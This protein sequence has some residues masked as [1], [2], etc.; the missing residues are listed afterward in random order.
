MKV[1]DFTLTVYMLLYLFTPNSFEETIR[2]RMNGFQLDAPDVY[3]LLASLVGPAILLSLIGLIAL[4]LQ[5]PLSDVA[6]QWVRMRWLVAMCIVVGVGGLLSI[7]LFSSQ[8]RE[9]TCHWLP[10]WSL[11]YVVLVLA[12]LNGLSPYLGYKTQGS[13]TMFSNL[14]TEHG[15]WNHLLMPRSMRVIDQ[16][17]DRLV[18]I[19]A[20]DDVVLN[21]LYVEQDLL[22]T[23]FEVRRRAMKNPSLSIT[24][25]RGNQEV[26]IG[27]ISQDPVLGAP[28]SVLARKLLVFRPVTPDGRPFV[29][30]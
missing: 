21:D 28:L 2:E 19:V 27:S 15:H 18:R 4:S 24:V 8:R 7:G 29:T 17:Q 10:R 9:S 23:E 6:P 3:A 22:A 14:R 25:K 26:A 1:Y 5:S 20:S 30:N 13:F 16:Y 12:I 11:P